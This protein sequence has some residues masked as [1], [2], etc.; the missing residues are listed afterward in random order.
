MA[1]INVTP[2]TD[3]T[4]LIASDNVNAGDVLLLEDG[5]YNQS[6]TIARNN[7]RIIA[8]GNNVVFDGRSTLTTA[9]T[10]QNVTRM[11][12]EGIKI[13]HYRS[14]GIQI[15]GG[16]GNRIINNKISNVLEI[17]IIMSNSS[18]N[19]IWKN[20]ISNCGYGIRLSQGST[21]N[22]IIENI[23]AECTDV[24]FENTSINENNNAYIYNKAIKNRLSGFNIPGS[25]TLLMDNI[26]TDNPWGIIMGQG[27][28]S[29]S[30]GNEFKENRIDALTIIQNNHFVA[31]NQIECTRQA[32]ILDQG[33]SGTISD[34]VISYN[35]NSGLFIVSI[36][37]LIM[38]NTLVCNVPENI[39]SGGTD[40][41]LMNN[42]EIPCGP[43]EAPGDVCSDCADKADNR[44]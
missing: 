34:N 31:E 9:F 11:V 26:V 21:N 8:R 42:A 29:V 37:D 14:N 32:G 5:I 36:G 25:N 12:I 17:G 40:N 28:S 19:L 2:L 20:E 15:D 43:C 4:E 35:G 18:A 44:F 24:G 33:R 30:V 1:I 10:L 27:N 6:V 7:I 38:D 13:E 39:S 41:I 16:S 3:I 23:A 22:W